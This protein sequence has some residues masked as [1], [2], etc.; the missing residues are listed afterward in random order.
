VGGSDVRVYGA[1]QDWEL[2]KA[3]S[4]VPTTAKKAVSAVKAGPDMRSVLV[5]S[6]DHNLRVFGAAA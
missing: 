3:W 6:G 1:K 4:D 2:L 5:G